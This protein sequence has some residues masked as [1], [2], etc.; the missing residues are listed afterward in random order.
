MN[1]EI[2]RSGKIVILDLHTARTRKNGLQFAIRLPLIDSLF[3]ELEF[4]A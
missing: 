2:S 1:F 4:E 3:L